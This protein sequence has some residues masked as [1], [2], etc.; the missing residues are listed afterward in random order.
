MFNPVALCFFLLYVLVLLV[1]IHLINHLLLISDS[2]TVD[3]LD[4]DALYHQAHPHR[5]R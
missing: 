2:N 1:D 4:N 3:D 5:L